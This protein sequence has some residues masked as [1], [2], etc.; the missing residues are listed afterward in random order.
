MLNLNI[1]LGVLWVDSFFCFFTQD[2][3]IIHQDLT[4]Y[5]CAIQSNFDI[6]L[7]IKRQV[8][9]SSQ[10]WTYNNWVIIALLVALS[11]L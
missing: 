9:D 7:V 6:G 11:S 3:A 1:F 10:D 5:M 8:R 2:R 4:D